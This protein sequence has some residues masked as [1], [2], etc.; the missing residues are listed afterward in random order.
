L[1]AGY[2]RMP[3][4][5]DAENKAMLHLNAKLVFMVEGQIIRFVRRIS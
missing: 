2:A 4:M 1:E 5:N 3:M